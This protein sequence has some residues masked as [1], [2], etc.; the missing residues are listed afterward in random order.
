VRG[1]NQRDGRKGG[2]GLTK[3]QRRTQQ[4]LRAALRALSLEASGINSPNAVRVPLPSAGSPQFAD[5]DVRSVY[6]E[7]VF[8]DPYEHLKHE[9]RAN[10]GG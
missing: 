4:R 1:G 2:G 7:H 8:K 9:R 3:G 6:V 10:L 5:P